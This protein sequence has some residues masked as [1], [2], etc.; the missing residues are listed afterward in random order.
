MSRVPNQGLVL[1]TFRLSL[2]TWIKAIK[3]IP[4]RHVHMSS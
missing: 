3:T 1:P 4:P 2:L